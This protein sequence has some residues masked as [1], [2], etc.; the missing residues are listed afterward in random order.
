MD[1]H[2]H[3]CMDTVY[4]SVFS[5]HIIATMAQALVIPFNNTINSP[6]FRIVLIMVLRLNKRSQMHF[7]IHKNTIRIQSNII[8][9]IVHKQLLLP[10]I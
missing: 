3:I 10:K 9:Q 1:V 4:Q 2:V 8:L 7:P 6:Q 5:V